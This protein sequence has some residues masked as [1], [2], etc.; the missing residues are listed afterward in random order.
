[1]IEITE[2]HRRI[3]D[4]LLEP[5]P[6]LQKYHEVLVD[7][8]RK[9]CAVYFFAVRGFIK[10]GWSENWRG[11]LSGIQSSN[12]EKIEVLLILG[13]PKIY[14]KT[15]HKKFSAHRSSGEWFKDHPDIRDFI[16]DRKSECWYR[17]GK[18]K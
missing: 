11:R 18:R 5:P 4:L 2:E 6:E 17:A 15:M 14:E 13:R 7:P 1:M 3:I 16:E 10:I 12:P 8:N 9:E